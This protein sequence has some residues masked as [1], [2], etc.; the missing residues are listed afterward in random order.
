MS[1]L[2]DGPKCA[3]HQSRTSVVEYLGRAVAPAMH[4]SRAF[5]VDDGITEEVQFFKNGRQCVRATRSSFSLRPF[6]ATYWRSWTLAPRRIAVTFKDSD[7]SAVIEVLG[8]SID[9]NSLTVS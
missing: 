8:R 2:A 9:T 4:S 3:Q 7:W 5:G 1:G 6:Q